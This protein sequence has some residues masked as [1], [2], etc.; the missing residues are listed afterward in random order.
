MAAPTPPRISTSLTDTT[1]GGA[2]GA[3]APVAGHA[4]GMAFGPIA[5]KLTTARAD[6]F[7]PAT[8][9]GNA[10]HQ[11]V[12]Q[13]GQ[14]VP[15]LR[16]EPARN[17]NLTLA[18]LNVPLQCAVGGMAQGGGGEA[19]ANRA[20]AAGRRGAGG[21]MLRGDFDAAIGAAPDPVALREHLAE[22][23]RTNA[24]QAFRP[25][26]RGAGEVNRRCVSWGFLSDLVIR[27]PRDRCR[28]SVERPRV[29]GLPSAPRLARTA[30]R[31]RP[32]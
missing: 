6:R 12:E 14:T 15:G 22:T 21:D 1:R 5:N 28:A 10:L 23:A 8:R 3:A 2:L 31:P 16:A 18:D 29:K 27:S 32:P 9:A 20:C 17:P 11:M 26:L 4:L 7:N 30:P 24:R 25:I 19:A 13:A